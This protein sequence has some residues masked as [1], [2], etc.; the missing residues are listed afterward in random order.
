LC[1][2]ECGTVKVLP[3]GANFAPNAVFG[4]NK[5]LQVAQ[6]MFH[7][8]SGVSRNMIAAR[9]ADASDLKGLGE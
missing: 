5:E 2:S 8:P 6:K 1:P 9:G 3:S 7:A 4:E